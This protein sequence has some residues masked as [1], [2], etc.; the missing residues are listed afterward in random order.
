MF[1]C[2]LFFP[3]FQR[4]PSN[5]SAAWCNSWAWW[6]Y[7]LPSS[8]VCLLSGWPQTAACERLRWVCEQCHAIPLCP[9]HLHSCQAAEYCRRGSLYDCLASAREQPPA[10]AQLT[11]RRRLGMAIDAGAGLLY[12]H[13]RSI[14]HRDG[15]CS[16]VASAYEHSLSITVCMWQCSCNRCRAQCAPM[17][18]DPALPCC[19]A[20]KSPNLLVDKDWNV[21]VAGE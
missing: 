17:P 3:L 20:V 4:L 12:L 14:I 5:C 10:A 6:L 18:H 15:E 21:K 16:V 11:W 7:P 8:Q 13:R 9:R 1:C 19:A 2:L